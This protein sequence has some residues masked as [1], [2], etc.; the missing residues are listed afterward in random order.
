VFVRRYEACDIGSASEWWSWSGSCSAAG[1][2][3]ML[4]CKDGGPWRSGMACW[5]VPFAM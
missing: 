4:S 1:V 3:R 5:A 2:A